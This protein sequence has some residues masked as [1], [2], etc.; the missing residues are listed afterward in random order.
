MYQPDAHP[1]RPSATRAGVR[2]V[3][4]LEVP[5]G[6]EEL[7]TRAAQLA[8]EFGQLVSHSL[9]GVRASNAVLPAGAQPRASASGRP[10][11]SVGLVID[12]AGR[13]VSVDG[14]TVELTYREFELIAYLFGQ[15]GRIVSRAELMRSVWI[16]RAQDGGASRT[17]DTHVRRL[18]AKL[19]A[20]A[21]AVTTV[22]GRGYRWEPGS[23]A[24]ART[25]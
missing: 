16:D 2:V 6:S 15:R 12:I 20:Y 4:V 17:V 23:A 25:G 11:Q 22:R 19:G 9:P 18:R 5:S 1:T 21:D 7:Q 8:N 14:H 3:L 13:R 24:R 10:L